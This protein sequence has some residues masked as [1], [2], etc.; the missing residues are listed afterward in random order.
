MNQRTTLF[1]KVLTDLR[2]KK[3]MSIPALT[4]KMGVSKAYISHTELGRRLPLADFW[5]KLRRSLELTPEELVKL[6]EVAV[7][8]KPEHME[9]LRKEAANVASRDSK[10]RG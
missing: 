8:S 4:K 3:N 1:G 5:V 10:L 6:M 7:K 9:V 2:I